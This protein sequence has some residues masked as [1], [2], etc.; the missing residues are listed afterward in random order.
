MF[1]RPLDIYDTS[2]ASST[3]PHPA[4]KRRRLSPSITSSSPS[5]PTPFSTPY[6]IPSDSPTN[7]FGRFRSHILS[8]PK[9]TSFS[10]H[11]PL[12]FQ[13]IRGKGGEKGEGVYR[14]V[15][16]PLNYTFKLLLKLVLFLFGGH[17]KVDLGSSSSKKTGRKEALK[18]RGTE[19]GDG[20]QKCVFEVQEGITMHRETHR[21]GQIRSAKTWVKVCPARDELDEDEEG[22]EF[23][24]DWSWRSE[25]D[26]TLSHVWPKGG[27]L[28]R[29]ITYVSNAWLSLGSFVL[30]C[31]HDSTT[32]RALKFT[33][34]S[35]L[36]PF[37][38]VR[39]SPTNH[40]Y[41][42]VEESYTC[43][44]TSLLPPLGYS[45]L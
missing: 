12:R 30:T 13:L 16:V 8:L 11:L 31:V 29:G 15:Q 39:A 43:V 35:T 38:T 2:P 21:P 22:D 17:P 42:A 10:R 33:S 20:G 14:I 24:R 41:F 32:T 7:P 6:N 3:P 18:N 19:S 40:T 28:E 27:D 23:E 5:Q 37:R 44:P 45:P 36:R 26:F 1:K 25:D 34:R 4:H 9:P